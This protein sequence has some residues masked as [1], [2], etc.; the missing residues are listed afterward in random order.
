MESELTKSP[1]NPLPPS[2]SHVPALH[3]L[4]RDQMVHHLA[5]KL[6]ADV[7]RNGAV[8]LAQGYCLLWGLPGF[9]R[10]GSDHGQRSPAG[11][12]WWRRWDLQVALAQGTAS[13]ALREPWLVLEYGAVQVATGS[14][15]GVH[16]LL[17]LLVVWVGPCQSGCT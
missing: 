10:V 3:L 8:L 16:V 7:L 4:L 13:R 12:S 9:S 14:S 1:H 15:P 6:V 11:R 5:P 17:A 2:V